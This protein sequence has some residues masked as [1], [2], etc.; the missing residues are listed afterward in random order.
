MEQSSDSGCEADVEDQSGD[1]G[2]SCDQSYWNGF[3]KYLLLGSNQMHHNVLFDVELS[4]T[5]HF[6][7]GYMNASSQAGEQSVL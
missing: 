1:T 5:I 2:E 7:T 4:P 6:G 3:A